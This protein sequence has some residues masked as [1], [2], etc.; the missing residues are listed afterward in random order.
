MSRDGTTGGA[1]RRGI[2]YGVF[3]AWFAATLVS[4]DPTRRTAGARRWDPVGLFVP[5]W[6]FFAPRPGTQDT[7]LL[8]RDEL[9]DG[10]LTEW[11][12]VMPVRERSLRH[13]LV[14]PGRR[15][16]KAVS[17]M[18]SWLLRA[19]GEAK[20]ERQ[21]SAVQATVSYVGLLTYVTRQAAHPATAVRTEFMLARS[22]GYEEAIE[23]EIAFLSNRH[24]LA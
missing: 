3:G 10:S 22:A 20:D 24:R 2:V 6:R 4:Q 9:A 15:A 14:H 8:Y 23:P 21:R 17:D 13:V 16:E 7:H 1:I 19:V 18:V 11:R 5:D 12:E